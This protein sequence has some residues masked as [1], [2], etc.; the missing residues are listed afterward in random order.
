MNSRSMALTLA[1]G[2]VLSVM[3][4]SDLVNLYANR[5]RIGNFLSSAL[6]P[7][8]AITVGAYPGSQKASSMAKEVLKG[9]YILH[10]RHAE[11][12]KWLD[13]VMYDALESDVHDN[14][15][16]GTRYAEGEYFNE[17]VC[18]NS[19]GLVQ[20]EAMAE[21]I[22]R[23]GMPVSYVISSPICRARQTAEIVFGGYNDLNRDLVHPGPYL[24]KKV[25]HVAKLR[26]LYLD[27]PLSAD[28]NTVVTA[29]DSLIQPDMFDEISPEIEWFTVEEGGFYVISRDGGKLTLEHQFYY[30]SDFSRTFYPR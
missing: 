21:N 19:R 2:S 27:L 11:R 26:Q 20:A 14:G 10:F 6:K 1:A 13:V 29:H 28:S 9:G 12:D 30:F 23:I 8:A 5:D 4:L 16:N 17:A 18:L 3:L 24:E 22:G 7:S 15:S 25:D